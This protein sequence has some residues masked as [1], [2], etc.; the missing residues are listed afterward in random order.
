MQIVNVSSKI[1][2][3]I[4]MSRLTCKIESDKKALKKKKK[5]DKK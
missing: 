3:K 1:S 4:S 5:N 2:F